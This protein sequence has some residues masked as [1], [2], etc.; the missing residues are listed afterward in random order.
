MEAHSFM[1]NRGF[2]V[3]SFGSG[4]TVKLPGPSQD[5]PNIYQFDSTTYEEIYQDLKTKD[6]SMYTQNGLLNMVDR[7]RHIKR[8]PQRFQNSDDHFNV[9]ICMEERVYDQIVDD[10]QTRSSVYTGESVHVI[11]FDVQ[12]NHEEAAVGALCIV[13]L[14]KKLE[15]CEDLD[16]EIDEVLAE[17]EAKHQDRNILHT[18]C[19][20]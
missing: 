12:D 14:C 20:Y 16:N 17:F 3:Q 15:D 7:N 10:L 19:F 2:D 4:N 18:L 8:C 9:I 5:R 1:Q 11:N 6:F 13:D